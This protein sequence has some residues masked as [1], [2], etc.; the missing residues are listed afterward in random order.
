M[1]GTVNMLLSLAKAIV[2]AAAAGAVSV[3]VQVLLAPTEIVFG[4]QAS[5]LSETGTACTVTAAILD[6][7]PSVAVML[8]V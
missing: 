6:T 4:A 3:T 8:P 5:E 7:L 2:M 1:A